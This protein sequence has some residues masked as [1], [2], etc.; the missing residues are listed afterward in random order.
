M[1]AV[2]WCE[3]LE[4]HCRRIYQAATDGD[5]EAA[6]LLGERLKASLP[7]PFG[8]RDVVRKGW[9]GL[10][11]ERDVSLAVGILEDRGWVRSQEVPAGPQGGRPTT[12]YWVHPAI[13]AAG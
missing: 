8:V 6:V 4:D 12:R 13:L 5:P 11:D 9:S 2:A 3:L 10:T 1:A 7:N